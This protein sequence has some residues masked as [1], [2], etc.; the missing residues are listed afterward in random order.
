[1]KVEAAGTPD[2]EGG[3]AIADSFVTS[4]AGVRDAYAHA[5]DGIAAITETEPKAFSDQVATV[6]TALNDEYSKTA[7]D[8]TD[9]NS[10]ELKEA[11]NE[12]PE[13]R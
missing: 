9:L 6:L 2:V 10:V 3:E 11:F 5:K 1:V 12:V 13:C 4:L 7:P 8:L